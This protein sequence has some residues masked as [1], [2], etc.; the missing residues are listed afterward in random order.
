MYSNYESGL[1]DLS[2]CDVGSIDSIE[3]DNDFYLNKLHELQAHPEYEYCT[4]TAGFLF[5]PRKPAVGWLLND[6]VVKQGIKTINK[7]EYTFYWYRK[8]NVYGTY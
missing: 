5:N 2:S 6:H 8:R 4:T 1:N 7:M 3:R